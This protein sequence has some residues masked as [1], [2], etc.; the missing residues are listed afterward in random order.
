MPGRAR[1]QRFELDMLA[2][3]PGESRPMY[4]QL[5]E[6]IREAVRTGGL[7][8]GEKLPST[9][10]LS[11][12]LGIGRNTTTAAYEQLI[13]EGYLEAEVG[14]GTR[15]SRQLP[16]TLLY[17]PAAL[18]ARGAGRQSPGL[19]ARGRDMVGDN[20]SAPPR[21]A[22][23]P[24]QP[25]YPAL[26]AFPHDLWRRL[27]N[28][29]LE[30]MPETLA[31]GVDSLGYPPLRQ[32][33]A[34]YLGASR[35][36]RCESEQ[37]VIIAGA[38]QGFELV[39][40][41]LLDPGDAMWM[42]EPGYR[43][44]SWV[45]EQAGIA[46]CP[47]PVDEAGLDVGAGKALSG[48]ARLAYVTPSSQWPMGITMSLPRRLELLAWAR[49]NRAWILEDDYTGEFRY[50]G[51]PLPAIHGLDDSGLVVYLGTFSKVLFPGIRLAYLVVPQE[52]SRAFAAARWKTGRYAA[53][54]EQAVLTDF[55]E[56]GHFARHL[57]RMRTLYGARQE[58]LLESLG[59]EMNGLLEVARRDAGM[60]LVA[61]A[62]SGIS[63]SVIVSAAAAAGIGFH[64]V[65]HYSARPEE[66]SGL[67]LGF[68]S[69]AED[70]IRAAAKAWAAACDRA[71]SR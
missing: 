66:V 32:A 54:L 41:L 16:E 29:R 18:A 14:S 50:A 64:Q 38:Q 60:Q 22:P 9:R 13:A 25:H 56:G 53:A 21:Q 15:V 48:Q 40:R 6:A 52:L 45:F 7:R 30:R 47:V 23:R 65:S 10:G 67:I 24:F 35:G 46:A 28:R 57:R 62:A 31:V 4:Q 8:P 26:D 2:V 5:A 19:S 59:S 34:D 36:V 55:I 12:A 58:A 44:A 39:A 70:Q 11:R 43:A 33:I 17:A 69:F 42:E 37:V 1:P 68:A 61:R 49:D 51:R 27:A 20:P 71:L 3:D 63:E